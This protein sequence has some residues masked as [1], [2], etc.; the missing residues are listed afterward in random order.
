MNIYI[1][2]YI[3]GDNLKIKPVLIG[4]NIFHTSSQIRPQAWH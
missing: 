4:T 3:Y 2:I 1:Y